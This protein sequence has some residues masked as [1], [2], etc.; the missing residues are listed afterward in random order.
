VRAIVLEAPIATQNDD[1]T[2]D[3]PETNA[4]RRLTRGATCHDEPFQTAVWPVKP[5]TRQ[6]PPRV[7]LRFVATP[8]LL[9]TGALATDFHFSTPDASAALLNDIDVAAVAATIASATAHLPHPCLP[10]RTAQTLP[11]GPAAHQRRPRPQIR[12]AHLR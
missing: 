3:T 5:T 4:T 1:V 10:R 9:T 2:Q 6:K 7:Q 8:S 11:H 12:K